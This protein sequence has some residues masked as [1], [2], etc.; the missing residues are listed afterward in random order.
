MTEKKNLFQKKKKQ[1]QKEE[2]G[3]V[4]CKII[5]FEGLT[6]QLNSIGLALERLSYSFACIN[7]SFQL[8]FDIFISLRLCSFVQG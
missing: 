5:L 4:L 1:S 3:L 7:Q 6:Q 8:Q 2:L